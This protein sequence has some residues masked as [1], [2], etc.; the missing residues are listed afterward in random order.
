MILLSN[1]ILSS[2]SSYNNLQCKLDQTLRSVFRNI[3]DSISYGIRHC[4]NK[5]YVYHR[6]SIAS[7][8]SIMHINNPIV[9]VEDDKQALLDGIKSLY[10]E[11]ISVFTI[12]NNDNMPNELSN[13][14]KE[15]N[16]YDELYF[17]CIGSEQ[18]VTT[19]LNTVNQIDDDL[20]QQGYFIHLHKYVFINIPS[21]S[22]STKL[23][24]YI[25]EIDNVLC[26]STK[27]KIEEDSSIQFYT[28]MYSESARYWD[29]VSNEYNRNDIKNTFLPATLFPNSQFKLN[30][31]FVR[32]GTNIAA[33]LLIRQ[34]N[35]GTYSGMFAEIMP[36]LATSLNFTY[37]IT[38]PKDGKWG[39]KQTD[40]SWNGLIGELHRKELDFS[41]W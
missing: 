8:F 6:K 24:R 10:F 41:A 3:N 5:D 25:N 2:N 7:V 33:D 23:L 16:I 34:N 35:N 38:L 31:K 37:N 29:I 30:K 13:L 32:M 11:T 40:G 22:C 18:F 26:A 20:G 36:Y 15:I 17:L 4:T 27:G 9:I 19:M 28:A 14:Y 1:F 39:T 21:M 12:E